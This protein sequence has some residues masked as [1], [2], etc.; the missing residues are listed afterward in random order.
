MS[1]GIYLRQSWEEAI[2][3]TILLIGY[4]CALSDIVGRASVVM[5]EVVTSLEIQK[6]AVLVVFVFFN[7]RNA[8]SCPW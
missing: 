7:I 4:I 6:T 8:K 2:L 5:V 3:T 1:A